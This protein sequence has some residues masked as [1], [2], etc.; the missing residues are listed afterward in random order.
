[1]Q[2]VDLLPSGVSSIMAQQGKA[3]GKELR[4]P[5]VAFCH[6]PLVPALL[7]AHSLPTPVF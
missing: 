3:E 7:L 1:M 4:P 6:L 2:D 5:A